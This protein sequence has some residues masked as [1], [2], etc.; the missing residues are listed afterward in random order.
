MLGNHLR[1]L[2]AHMEWADSVVCRSVL[3]LEEAESDANMAVS[4]R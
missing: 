1:D 4:R 2:I 3:A